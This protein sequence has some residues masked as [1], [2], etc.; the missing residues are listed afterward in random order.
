[1]I[2]YT[3]AH[4]T[5]G[6][7]SMAPPRGPARRYER[8]E[9]VA[10]IHGIDPQGEVAHILVHKKGDSVRLSGKFGEHKVS[11]SNEADLEKW[12]HEAATVWALN[13]AIGIPRGWMNKP[14]NLEKIELINI[15]AAEKKKELEALP[16][17]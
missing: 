1:M 3:Q 11:R 10:Y 5:A 7:F 14:E 13:D 8:E 12:I 4:P 16:Q 17:L 15:K 9:M 6:D 2:P